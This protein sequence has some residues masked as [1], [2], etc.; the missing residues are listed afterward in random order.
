M[1]LILLTLFLI[2]LTANAQPVTEAKEKALSVVNE[3]TGHI[4]RYSLVKA[5]FDW[6]GF[7][8]EISAIDATKFHPDSLMIPYIITLKKY[9]EKGGDNHSFY[10][11]P[12]STSNFKA[13]NSSLKMPVVSLLDKNI[14]IIKMPGIV[15][16]N[17]DDI[18]RYADTLRMQIKA[19]DKDENIKG[20]I[21]DLRK[22][23]GGT[24][25]PMLAGLNPLLDDGTAGYFIDP[26]NKLTPWELSEKK[27]FGVGKL[28]IT[29]KCQDRSKKIA[30]LMDSLT[31]SSGEMTVIAFL[32]LPN[33]RTFGQPT[34][35]FTT[36]NTTIP[37]SNGGVLLLA[38]K[39]SA[40]RN[41]VIYKGPI[42]PDV[43]TKYDESVT[44]ALNWI[45]G[46]MYKQ[47]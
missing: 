36:A 14:A 12:K 42:I 44:V 30:V 47:Y 1:R 3:I 19:V 39:Y 27:P 17:K 29:Y 2:S 5:T 6:K 28:D 38:T 41:K 33:V 43:A 24:M 16:F 7:D 13:G 34:Y 32:G 45:A 26:N 8:N 25:W 31:G 40:D 9:L 35:G 21:V 4:K 11:G 15:S 46:N 22:N 10:I 23:G 37:L 20:W 18:Q